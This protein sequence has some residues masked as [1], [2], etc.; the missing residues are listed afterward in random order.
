MYDPSSSANIN[1]ATIDHFSLDWT[2][3]FSKSQI[4]G[5]AVLSILDSRSLEIASITLD[6][7]ILD[8]REESAG[9]LG[10]KIVIDV[11]KRQNGE[12]FNLTIIY[13]TGK[14]CSA[15][16]FLKAE[17]T[18]TKEKPYLFSQCEHIHA[19]S[20]VPCMDTPSVK[21]SYDAL[22]AVPSA[23]VCLMSAVAV[24]EPEEIGN[25]KKYSFKQSIRIPS[26]LLA[27]VVGLMEK[28]DLSTRCAIWAEPTVIDRAFYE[29]GE[30]EE[31]LK[32]AENL[33]GKYEW[34]RY[35]L[36]VLP[37]SF[38]F[39][40]MENP[41]LTFVTPTLLAGDRSAAYVIAHEI[42][43][44]W[45]GNL[46]SNANWEHFWLNEGFTTFLE[47][48]IIGKLKGEKQRQ[49]EAQC[50]WEGNMM[51][52]IEEQF[53][54]D[55]PFTKL[56]PN[57]QNIDPEDAYSVIPYE[58]GSAFLMV[59]EQQLGVPQFNEFLKK[60]IE[61]FAQKSIVTDDWKAFLY[62][63]F[64][65]KKNVLDSI[66]WNNW[67]HDAGIP[68]TKP[69]FDDTAMRE[70]VALANEWIDLRD[71]QIMDITNSKFLSLSTLQK[72]KVLTHLRLA[73]KEISHAKLAR[74]DEVN[75]LSKTGNCDIL[76]SWIQLCLK[77]YWENI[78]PVAFDFVTRQGRIKYVRPIYRDL[79]LWSES[80]GSAIELLKKNAPSMHPVTVSVVA[81]LI[82]K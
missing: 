27:I 60:Y 70:V 36:V 48:K 59:L 53:P 47:R 22:V 38:P 61:K 52:A 29:F 54:N 8:Y 58:K 55:H 35:D 40:G 68:K 32:A 4:S 64:S 66:D 57:L 72:E 43:H 82:P 1:E 16:Q 18:A 10:E 20:I 13:N 80:A 46:V 65:D 6:N 63:Y 9:V 7:K 71:S 81:K 69:Q 44:S 21:Q 49:F 26:Y 30:A 77:N 39:G 28:R 2:I 67:L 78:I 19:R 15:L 41:C 23:L 51:S 74:I 62:E 24:G 34:G 14:K 12:K 75:Q 50:G 25:L 45:T 76:S 33:V 31:M 73:K 42:S 37:A 17:Q 11:G 5:S 3:D 56:I 79:F